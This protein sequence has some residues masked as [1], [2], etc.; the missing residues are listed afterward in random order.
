MDHKALWLDRLPDEVSFWRH[1]LH[2]DE[3]RDDRER[4]LVPNRE[5]RPYVGAL[6]D[7]VGPQEEWWVLDV[8]AGPVTALGRRHGAGRVRVVAVDPLADY[9]DVLLDAAGVTPPVRTTWCHGELLLERFAPASFDMTYAQN[10]LDHS[11]DPL[12]IIR[13]MVDLTKPGGTVLLEHR[14]NE[15]ENEQYH[16]LHQWNFDLEGHAVVLWD[17]HHRVALHEALA[18]RVTVTPWYVPDVNW[19]NVQLRVLPDGERPEPPPRRWWARRR[20]GGR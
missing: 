19:L 1:W 8:G 17:A 10:A 20:P 2:D 13:H 6:L 15:G 11:Y 18:G 9:Y 3:F 16:G 4:R 14:R 7:A 5:V 12:A